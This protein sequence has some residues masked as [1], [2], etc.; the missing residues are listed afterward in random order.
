[1][2]F[3]PCR[4]W[5]RKGVF[6]ELFLTYIGLRTIPW[7]TKVICFA[8]PY[9]SEHPTMHEARVLLA[10]AIKEAIQVKELAE[11]SIRGVVMVC[12]PC[13]MG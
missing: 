13:A 10:M 11:Y 12:M 7:Y 5:L 8:H 2:L 4:Q 9:P 6:S 3:N 1:M